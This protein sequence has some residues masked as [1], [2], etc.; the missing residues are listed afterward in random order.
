MSHNYSLYSKNC[1]HN[2]AANAEVFLYFMFFKM[3]ESHLDFLVDTISNWR[4]TNNF[5]KLK[6]L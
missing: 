5:A 6:N 2:C 1:G 3:Q 4:F